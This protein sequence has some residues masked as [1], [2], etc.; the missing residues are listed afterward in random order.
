LELKRK[1]IGIE[2]DEKFFKKGEE[3]FAPNE[4]ISPTD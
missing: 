2:K 4:I 3:R 1:A